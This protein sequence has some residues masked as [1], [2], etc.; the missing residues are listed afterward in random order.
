MS[1][2]AKKQKLAAGS[3][4]AAV[5]APPPPPPARPPA[6]SDATLRAALRPGQFV[7]VGQQSAESGETEYTLHRFVS[8][9]ASGAQLVEYEPD[10]SGQSA[11]PQQ[12]VRCDWSEQ[13]CLP[14]RPSLVSGATV[15]ALYIDA[16]GALTTVYY[17][18]VLQPLGKGKT[19]KSKDR[20]VEF[21]EG[22]VQTLPVTATFD[23]VQLPAI[24]TVRHEHSGAASYLRH[25]S[26][27]PTDTAAL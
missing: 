26:Q 23:G 22:Q 7:V 1:S 24:M 8:V 19:T 18:G 20:Q 13:L 25:S 14:V 15:Y 11:T 6:L 10:G 17:R 3:V 27:P 2:S 16:V 21:A 4:A 9:S 12:T 5:S